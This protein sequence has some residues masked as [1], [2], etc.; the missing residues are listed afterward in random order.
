MDYKNIF[1]FAIFFL[2]G[3]SFVLAAPSAPTSLVFNNNATPSYDEGNF[4]FNWSSVGGDAVANYTVYLYSNNTFYATAQNTSATGYSFSN[5]TEAN[6]TFIVEAWNATGV[7]A[8]SSNNVSLYV[9]SSSPDISIIDFTNATAKQNSSTLTLNISVTDG[10]SGLIG[11]VCLIDVNGT[12]Q[13]IS[14]SS[15]W[16]NATN[17]NL[18]GLSDGNRTIRVY[19]ND[20]V[21]NLGEDNS[22]VVQMDTT[23]PVPSA[24]CTPSTVNIGNTVTCS[25]SGTDATSGIASQTA[26]SNPSTSNT[27]TFS[28]SCNVTDNAGNFAEISASYTVQR[29]GG[30]SFFPKANEWS[31]ENTYY[32]SRINF[33][34]S[35]FTENFDSEIGLREIEFNVNKVSNDVRVTVRSYENKPSQV[36]V[37][38]SG[39]VN[40][41]LEID[42]FNIEDNL[43][44]F[45]R[46]KVE[47]SWISSNGLHK[48]D[49]SLFK[50]DE[51]TG[52]W[53]EISTVYL[54]ED[55]TFYYYES[56][57]IS[58]SYFAIGEKVL[59]QEESGQ[60]EEGGDS[61]IDRIFGG[62]NED[63]KEGSSK[64]FWVWVIVLLVVFIVIIY[65]S[66]K[67]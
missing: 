9:D 2:F 15:G 53:N 44:A 47:K 40:Q 4:F 8:N 63:K 57:V 1:F 30:G 38:K 28:Y 52:E 17:I 45:V 43:E 6:Y 19:V 11:S 3:I 56:K 22:Y 39:K 41:Y 55:S 33:G 49:V 61:L 24:S 18:S 29:S 67:K 10:L 42:V 58:F 36:P 50:Y 23:D 25:C 66:R 32:F 7:T 34:E 62:D 37:S 20:T 54:E 60:D 26:S 16:C 13:S 59:L 21:N 31:A 14:I 46:T 65:F 12:N 51:N 5:A 64:G 35:F 48:D 27:G